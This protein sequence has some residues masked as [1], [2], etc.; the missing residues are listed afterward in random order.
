[1]WG[2]PLHIKNLMS[3]QIM[4]I[5]GLYIQF[6]KASRQSSINALLTVVSSVSVSIIFST[7]GFKWS[8]SSINSFL[9]NKSK[10]LGTFLMWH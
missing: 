5:R 2:N 7:W 6:N 4:T 9:K 8:L 1:M 10:Y 3:N